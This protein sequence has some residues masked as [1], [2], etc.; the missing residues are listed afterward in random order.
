MIDGVTAFGCW[1]Q[2]GWQ[3]PLPANLSLRPR[4]SATLLL[5]V[6]NSLLAPTMI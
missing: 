5:I 4:I 2:T 1:L 6:S 3:Q